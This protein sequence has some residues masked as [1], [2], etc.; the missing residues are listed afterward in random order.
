MKRFLTM[1]LA[2]MLLCMCGTTGLAEKGNEITPFAA[3]VQNIVAD[4]NVSLGTAKCSALMYANSS[5]T[6][7]KLT[8][9]LQCRESF[10]SSWLPMKSWSASASGKTAATLSKTLSVSRGY[11][12]RVYARGTVTNS[13]GVVLD[14]ASAYSKVAYY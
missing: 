7:T 9:T 4:V 14:T 13:E 12:Y 1:C 3:Y 2:L 6:K 10:G 8:M 5:D 11:D